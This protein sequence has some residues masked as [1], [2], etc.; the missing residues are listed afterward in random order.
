MYIS[1][2]P[3]QAIQFV[4]DSLTSYPISYGKSQDSGKLE[5]TYIVHSK[6]GCMPGQPT[7][8]MDSSITTPKLNSPIH[9]NRI[10]RAFKLDK[11]K[12]SKLAIG[13]KS[14]HTVR[15]LF[16]YDQY[17]PND[18]ESLYISIKAAYRQIYGNFHAFESEK[19]IEKERKLRNGDITIKEFVRQLSKSPFYKAHYFDNVNQQRFI[20]LNF[21]HILGRPPFNQAEVI[22]SIELIN[23]EGFYRHVDY[24][25]DS[26]EYYETFGEHTVPF[27]RCWNSSTG[28]RSSSFLNSYK[29]VKSFSS[30]DNAIHSRHK[31]VSIS[32]QSIL[33]ND[34]I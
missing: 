1:N 28:I 3:I 9:E 13:I 22:N 14:A 17:H 8:F 31:D 18:D 25:I 4:A 2:L 12:D 23:R 30:S 10:T 29:I 15:N 20:E 26:D 24:L 16:T 34:L 33:L 21:K 7:V 19:P 11:L 5:T 6:G 32:G 27:M